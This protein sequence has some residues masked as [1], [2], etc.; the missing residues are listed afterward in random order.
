MGFNEYTW[1]TKAGEKIPVGELS[2]AHLANIIKMLRLDGE[3]LQQR[4]HALRFYLA[5]RE[6]QQ[7]QLLHEYCMDE[8]NDN[9]GS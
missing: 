3:T 5:E 4:R 6:A 1:T 8:A 9:Y 2:E 7:E